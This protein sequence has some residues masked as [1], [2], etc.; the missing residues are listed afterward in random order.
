MKELNIRCSSIGYIMTDPRLKS[1]TLSETCKNHLVDLFVADKYNRHTDTFNKYVEKGLAVEE[2]SITLYSRVKKKFFKKNDQRLTNKY[3]NGEPDLF[4]GIEIKEAESIIDIKSSWDL[5]TFMR[6]KFASV[7][8]HYWWQLQGYMALTGAKRSVL[9]YCLTNTPAQMI[10]DEQR[11]LMWRMG[12]ATSENEEYQKACAEL[13]R[14]M[15]YDDIPLKDRVHEIE[16]PRDDESIE[17]I[18]K[19]IEDCREYYQ[20]TFFN[21]SELLLASFDKQLSATIIEP[22]NI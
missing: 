17:K 16:I 6:T 22:T 2:D 19:K 7:N 11:K 12:I 9:A 21:K 8:K 20:Q 18:Y 3:I 1:E 15:T 13:E 5:Y 10:F 4:E 14:N